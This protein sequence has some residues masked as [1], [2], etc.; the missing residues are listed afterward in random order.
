MNPLPPELE[1]SLAL[2]PISS[3]METEE[4]SDNDSKPQTS[5]ETAHMSSDNKTCSAESQSL[6]VSAAAL[7]L[8]QGSAKSLVIACDTLQS[9]GELNTRNELAESSSEPN[10]STSEPNESSSATSQ[11]IEEPDSSSSELRQDSELAD[12]FDE[13]SIELADGPSVSYTR[14]E[15]RS[16]VDLDSLSAE[17]VLAYLE[18]PVCILPP[19]SGPI[20][21][22]PTGQ[23]RSS[24]TLVTSS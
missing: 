19:R 4:L 1:L 23:S 10:E 24:S 5:P 12:K 20:Y 16:Q 15:E 21:Q 8:T 17:S 7:E 3:E 14:D 22:C 6:S 11:T 9:S 13:S 2:C 18:C